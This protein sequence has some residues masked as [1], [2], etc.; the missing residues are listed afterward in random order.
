LLVAT[1][2]HVVVAGEAA[3]PGT[4]RWEDLVARG[5]ADAPGPPLDANDV[6]AMVYTS[7]TTSEPKGVQHTH[8]TLLA[9]RG[10]ARASATGR[11]AAPSLHLFPAGHIAGALGT[12]FMFAA[13]TTTV[14][15][16]TF[17]PELVIRSIEEF[18]LESTAGAPVFLSAILDLVETGER[19]LSSLKSFMVGAASVPPELVER[20]DRLGIKA[21]RCY[22]S[23]EHPTVTSSGPSD[24]LAVRAGTDGPCLPGNRVRIV[25]D[26]GRDLPIGRQGEITTLGPELFVGYR[27]ETLN[28]DAFLPGGWF[29]T[30]DLGVLDSAGNLTVTDRKK[31]III[32]GGENISAK[33]VEDILA[34]HPSV[35]E[36][37]V[38][39]M[40][41]RRLGER[42][43][44]FVVTRAGQRLGLEDV[45]EHFARAGVAH[46]KT[47]E[48]VVIVDDL[49]RTPAGKV[50]KFELR[51]VVR[52]GA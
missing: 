41:D 32:R 5:D 14:T 33:E 42:V 34:R 15:F 11:G 45:R 50:K 29:L 43:C 4:L 17:G 47:P 16:D 21:F 1:P 20:A 27:D 13:S 40:P 19:D 18:R 8:N 2:D 48:R 3:A 12:I 28:A 6:C 51:D 10:G 22:G 26:D 25:D 49:P 37:A 36:A 39:A 44:A 46:Q 35:S 38:V 7:G 9:E 52:R 24:P 23:S 30:G 31:D